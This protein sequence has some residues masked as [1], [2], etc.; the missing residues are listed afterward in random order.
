MA[1][2]SPMTT[3]A[4][5]RRYLERAGR[6]GCESSEIL[7]FGVDAIDRHLPQGGLTRGHLHEAIDGGS[8][9]SVCRARTLFVAGILARMGRPSIVDLTEMCL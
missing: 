8:C 7:P 1:C 9:Q 6:S 3:I 4:E 5:M 2:A